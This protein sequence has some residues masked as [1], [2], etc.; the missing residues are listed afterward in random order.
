M[1]RSSECTEQ[2]A[3]KVFDRDPH[4]QRGLVSSTTHLPDKTDLL[5]ILLRPSGNEEATLNR[6][7]L[8]VLC[9]CPLFGG[10]VL[11]A[12]QPDSSAH[13][14]AQPAPAEASVAPRIDPEKKADIR[15]FMRLTG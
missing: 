8:C 13:V 9:L 2:Y 3:Q 5:A 4:C 10:S 7:L 1:A 11:S 6:I 12:Q 14:P 15:R